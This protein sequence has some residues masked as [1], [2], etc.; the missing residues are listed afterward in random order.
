MASYI[1]RRATTDDLAQMTALW[2]T[3]RLPTAELEKRFTEF[4]VAADE[5][6]S[7][8]AAIGLN[9]AGKE[10]CVHSEAFFDFGL[11]DIVRPMLW[12]RLQKVAKAQGLYRL[13]TEESAPFWKKDAGFVHAPT[14][15]L[16]TKLPEVF[17]PAARPWLNLRL[18]QEGADPD[19]LDREFVLF[20]QAEEAKR[21]ELYRKA[22]LLNTVAVIIAALVLFFIAYKTI[23]LLVWRHRQ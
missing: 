3:V 7:V 14:E 13:W 10:G 15:E 12:E 5:K 8:V 17:G 4:H 21:S 23:N 18:R 16:L 11:T 20:K 19:A 9:I 1:I 2:E 6:D 22:S